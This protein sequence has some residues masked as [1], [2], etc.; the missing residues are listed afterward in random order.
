LRSTNAMID[1]VNIV[2]PN[3]HRAITFIVGFYDVST[4]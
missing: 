4:M 1:A 3:C 2:L